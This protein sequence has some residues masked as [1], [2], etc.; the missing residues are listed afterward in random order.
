MRA[1]ARL[2]I[3]RFLIIED[4]FMGFFCWSIG[5]FWGGARGMVERRWPDVLWFFRP[6]A[7]TSGALLLQGFGVVLVWNFGLIFGGR[8]VCARACAAGF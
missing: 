3:N 4:Y 2:V 1:P 7:G 6:G 8:R 5:I